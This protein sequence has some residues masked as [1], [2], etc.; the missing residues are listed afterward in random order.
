M[1]WHNTNMQATYKKGENMCALYE[2]DIIKSTGKLRFARGTHENLI[3]QG[4]PP[5]V[6]ENQSIGRKSGR[7]VN[8]VII[9]KEDK[10]VFRPTV[11]RTS[12]GLSIAGTRITLYQIMDYVKANE[13]PEVIRDH[14]RLTI[15]QTEDV[16][17]YIKIYY[18]EVQK[19]YLKIV[20]Q[21]EKN[22]QYWYERNKE[23]FD[24]IAKYPRNP[25]YKKVWAKI[26]ELKENRI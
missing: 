15:R 21:S 25:E 19:E 18:D 4:H 26:D 17:N 2:Y 5:A 20:T 3:Y 1:Q 16:L 8:E 23:R 13:P 9:M 22:R 11:I 6:S 12:R 7:G 10:S 14:F 24:K